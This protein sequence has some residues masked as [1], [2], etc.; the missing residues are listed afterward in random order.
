MV[1]SHPD[2]VVSEAYGDVAKKVVNRLEELAKKE[3]F[4]PEITL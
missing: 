2:S 1:V 4:R 3:H